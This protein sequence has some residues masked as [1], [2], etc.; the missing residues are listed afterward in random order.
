MQGV[1]WW[2]LYDRIR[3]LKT[4]TKETPLFPLPGKCNVCPVQVATALTGCRGIISS[5][6]PISGRFLVTPVWISE[7][8]G[9]LLCSGSRGYFG[10]LLARGTGAEL[11]EGDHI[12]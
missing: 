11:Q 12:K 5:L 6:C 10:P 2:L 7:A 1:S 4:P 3:D 9:C 8:G